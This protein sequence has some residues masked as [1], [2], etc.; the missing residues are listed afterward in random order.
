[1][2]VIDQSNNFQQESVGERLRRARIEKKISYER[3]EEVTKIKIKYLQAMENNDFSALPSW[4]YTRGFLQSYAKYLGLSPKPLLLQYKR[5]MGE[6]KNPAKVV[7]APQDKIRAFRLYITPVTLFAAFLIVAVLGVFFYIAFQL[8]IFA[9]TPYLLIESPNYGA[10]VFSDSVTISGKTSRGATLHI[11]GQSLPV[12]TD[13]RFQQ[14][15]KLK[16][17]EN[18]IVV[19]VSNRTGKT[20]K[21]EIVVIYKPQSV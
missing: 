17:G 9:G 5:E 2:M 7:L 11:N 8:S 14:K 10:V 12:N 4:V 13:G 18:S 19:S 20:A 15:V 3:A 6:M 16:E 1:M 21:K